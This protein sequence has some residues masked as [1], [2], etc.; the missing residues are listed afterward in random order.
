MVHLN[1]GFIHNSNKTNT[2]PLFFQENEG[3][4][5]LELKFLRKF[6]ILIRKVFLINDVFRETEFTLL[7]TL[8]LGEAKL[9]VR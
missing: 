3:V 1:Y 8:F 2:S 6:T 7:T 4:N 9:N 5:N